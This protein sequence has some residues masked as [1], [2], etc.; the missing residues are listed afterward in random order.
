MTDTREDLE[1]L[2]SLEFEESHE[3]ETKE[4]DAEATW[5]ATWSCSCI[6]K[7]CNTHFRFITMQALKGNVECKRHNIPVGD[8]M[9]V[10]VKKIKK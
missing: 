9:V 8:N 5:L 2:Q 3:C 10:N 6:F 7:Y 1:L 4:C